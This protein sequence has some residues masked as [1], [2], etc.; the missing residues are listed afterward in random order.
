MVAVETGKPEEGV[1]WHLRALSLLMQIGSP[2]AP[3]PLR[4]LVKEEDL[5]GQDRFREILDEHLDE[6]NRDAVLGLMEQVRQ[7]H[8]AAEAEAG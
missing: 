2:E 1:P 7:A 6:E 8:Q 4:Q 3:K 5:L